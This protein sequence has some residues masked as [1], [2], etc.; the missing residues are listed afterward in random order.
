VT[1]LFASGPR[2]SGCAPRSSARGARVVDR[3]PRARERGAAGLLASATAA[4]LET[5]AARTVALGAVNFEWTITIDVGSDDGVERDMPVI[6]GDGLVGR[7]SRS[8]P[9]PRGC[10]S[11][12]T[13]TSRR[14]PRRDDRRDRHDRRPRRRAA[15]LPPL[16]PDADLEVGDEIVTSAYQGGVFPGG[17]PIGTSPPSAS[18][19]PAD[20]RGPV[21]PFVDFTRLHHVLVV[22]SAPVDDLPPLEGHSGRARVHPD[23]RRPPSR[24]R[25]RSTPEDLERRRRRRDDDGTDEGD[26]TGRRP[27]GT[28]DG[29]DP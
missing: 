3:R 27:T 12:S 2:T 9:T 14:R 22:V 5:V 20:A 1:D 28:D 4:E 29:D 19:P 15:R 10:C 13:R 7:S 25:R 21:R 18:R 24:T 8:R 11:P 23:P 16:D 17:I 26:P 6:N